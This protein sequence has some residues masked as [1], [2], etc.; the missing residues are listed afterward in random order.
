LIVAIR[1]DGVG[2]PILVNGKRNGI[3]LV[4]RL[5]EQ[6]GGTTTLRSEHG[7]E[8][9]LTVPTAA[10]TQPLSRV[11]SLTPDSEEAGSTPG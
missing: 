10:G 9:V 8:W 4:K 7:T 11:P 6:L 5:I 1:D 2:F 3:G